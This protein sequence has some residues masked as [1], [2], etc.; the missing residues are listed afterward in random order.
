M[1]ILLLFFLF[2]FFWLFFFPSPFFPSASSEKF[3]H[4][5]IGDKINQ[6]VELKH[7]LDLNNLFAVI[8]NCSSISLVMLMAQIRV[9]SIPSSERAN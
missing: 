4:Q 5:K 7:M 2:F 3:C 9:K 8:N 6:P 1:A